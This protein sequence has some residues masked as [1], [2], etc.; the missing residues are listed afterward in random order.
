MP[1]ILLRGIAKRFDGRIAIDHIDLEI[2][3]GEYMAILG[4]TGAGK[5]TLLR[6]I[7]RLTQPDEGDVLIGGR[8]VTKLPPEERGLTY[9]SQTYSLFPHL[10]MWENVRF[11][12]EVKGLPPTDTDRLA[13]EM[14]LLVNLL[15]RRDAFPKELSGGM[16]QRTALAR[17]LA[18]GTSVLLLDE[19]LRALD[20]RL[21]I[22]LRLS[23]RK[24]CKDLGITALHVTH[25]QEEALLVAD[26]VAILRHGKI[27]QLGLSRQVYDDPS[28]PFVAQFLGEADFFL[29]EVDEVTPERTLLHSKTRHW[30]ARPSKLHPGQDACLAVKS[31][32]VRVLK[33]GE[34]A[35]NT[36]EAEVTRRLFLGK[37]IGLEMTSAE[38]TL[39]VKVR[40]RAEEGEQIKE[41][42]KVRLA[43]EPRN[44]M[45][46]PIPPGGLAKELEVE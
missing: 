28:G 9:M 2:K 11:S 5:T 19:P 12:P 13:R 27:E 43:V 16:Q 33:D 15:D 32:N 41:G 1:D 7:A 20:A 39:P 17:A 23:I 37:F 30:E 40:L 34:D 29:G 6:M 10:S 38:T 45:V 3:N 24:L 8:D 26:R 31:E 21:R 4:P 18:A 36:F 22:A 14:L 35:V 42:S 46:F 25:D 44:F